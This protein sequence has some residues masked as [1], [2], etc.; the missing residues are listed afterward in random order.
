LIGQFDNDIHAFDTFS[1][2]SPDAQLTLVM[3]D[4]KEAITYSVKEWK[5]IFNTNTWAISGYGTVFSQQQQGMIPATLELWYAT[6]KKYQKQLKDVHAQR[7]LLID[8][9]KHATQS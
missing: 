2:G 9:Y 4:T 6:R 8:K 5:E 3:E 7:E 1:S